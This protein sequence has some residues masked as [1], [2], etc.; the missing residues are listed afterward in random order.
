MR[1][2]P[3]EGLWRH[4]DFLKLWSAE[5]I[6]QF[7]TAI[8]GL[9]LPLVAIIVLHA[10]AFEVAALATIEFAPFIVF[11]LPAGVWVDRLRRRPVLIAG[12][13]GRAALL[14]SI[15]IVYALDALTIWQ[16]YAVGFVFGTFTVFFDVAYQSYLP[17][18]VER[19]D[20]AEGNSKLEI[21][22]SAAQ[23]G[24]PGFAGTVIGLLTAPYAIVLD[25]IS[26]LGSGLLLFAIRKEEAGPVREGVSQR[27]NMRSELGEG[28]RFVFGH[29]YLRSIAA[30]TATFNFFGNIAGAIL[31]VYL[32]RTVHM[33]PGLIGLVFSLASI[34]SL[35]GAV[36]ANRIAGRIGVGRTIVWAQAA[37]LVGIL[38]PLA[39]QDKYRA[40]P[41]LVV[42]EAVIAASIVIYNV[43]QLS[44]RQA[45]C[46]ERLQ[47][48]MNAVMRFLVWG[49]I[50]LGNLVGGALASTIGLR[51]T[52]WIGFV[53]AIL[54]ILPVA[55]SP[56][57]SVER[58]PEQVEESAVFEPLAVDAAALVAEPPGV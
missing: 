27:R 8:T 22:R 45:L 25:A 29:R 5:T 11:S 31:L 26:F 13:L 7:G 4:R 52:I 58:I 46:P 33:T 50:P 16:L 10:S 12:D 20:L 32:V 54:A 40:I 51:P 35:V 39:P 18:L 44:L 49:T 6:S 17:S 42:A 53:G 28:L 19:R 30:S 57:R 34:G 43:N 38:I 24:G 1:T 21:S 3:Q 41:Y 14:A 9:A 37:T 47:G 55:L 15:P 36:T 56:V 2:W 23:I 48:R